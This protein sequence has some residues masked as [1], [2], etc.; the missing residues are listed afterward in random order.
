MPADPS[1]DEIN[2]FHLSSKVMTSISV[3]NP[4]RIRVTTDRK[5]KFSSEVTMKNKCNSY[6]ASLSLYRLLHAAMIRLLYHLAGCARWTDDAILYRIQ[7]IRTPRHPD[8]VR[9]RPVPCQ[10]YYFIVAVRSSGPNEK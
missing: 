9:L 4:G 6:S 1:Y 8:S 10:T 7:Y 5:R 3:L 2:T